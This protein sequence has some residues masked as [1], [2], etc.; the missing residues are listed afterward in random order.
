MYGRD[1]AQ[2]ELIMK[3]LLPTILLGTLVAFAPVT[4]TRVIAAESA[5]TPSA[6]PTPSVTPTPSATIIRPADAKPTKINQGALFPHS[7]FDRAL[8]KAVNT[9]GE[10]TY[11]DLKGDADLEFYIAALALADVSKFPV[12]IRK[13]AKT[14]KEFEDRNFE[15][16]FWINAY[17]ATVLK[18]IADAWPI[19]N[20]GEIKD[21]ETAKTHQIAGQAWSLR[22]VRQKIAKLEPRALFALSDGTRGG[23]LLAPTAYRYATINSSLE[24]VAQTFI[25][26]PRNITISRINNTVV[27]SDFFR[28]INPYF[29]KKNDA[30]RM[31]GVR[32]LLALYSTRGADRNYLTTTDYRLDFANAS[33]AINA[34]SR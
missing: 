23:P 22:D 10:V 18:T 30:K 32:S 6:T 26:D 24:R 11:S 4:S 33:R 13:D 5:P 31:D 29:S 3:L 15:L 12:L 7:V 9:S 1:A 17:N 25:S 27:I 14:G 2:W 34:K 28:G 21:F 8:N 16:V 19:A 20:T